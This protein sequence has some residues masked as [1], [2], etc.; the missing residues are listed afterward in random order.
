MSKT[1][2][3][4]YVVDGDRLLN[5]IFSSNPSMTHFTTRGVLLEP[6]KDIAPRETEAGYLISKFEDCAGL[7]ECIEPK[8]ASR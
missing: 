8:R 6:N 2:T 5:D 7:L 1:T 4:L 3:F